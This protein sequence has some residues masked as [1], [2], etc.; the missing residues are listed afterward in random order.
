MVYDDVQSHVDGTFIA[1]VYY[2]SEI[3][4]CHPDNQYFVHGRVT[5]SREMLTPITPPL[6]AG[7]GDVLPCPVAFSLSD[8]CGKIYCIL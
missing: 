2:N 3:L 7:S 8:V 5:H 6:W 1:Q 4:V